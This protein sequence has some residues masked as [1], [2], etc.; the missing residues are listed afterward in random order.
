MESGRGSWNGWRTKGLK[1]LGFARSRLVPEVE[2]KGKGGI[3]Q[4]GW[5]PGALR[6]GLGRCFSAFVPSVPQTLQW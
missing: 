2:G 6:L 3:I 4:C 1:G 5:R